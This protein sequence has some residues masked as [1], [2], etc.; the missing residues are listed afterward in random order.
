MLINELMIDEKILVI[1]PDESLKTTD[2]EK[3]SKEVGSHIE[4]KDTLNGLMICSASFPG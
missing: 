3:L 2:F 4:S 1:T